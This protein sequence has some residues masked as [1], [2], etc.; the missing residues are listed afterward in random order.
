MSVNLRRFLPGEIYISRHEAWTILKFFWPQSRLTEQELTPDD[1]NFAQGLLVEAIDAS[2]KMGFAHIMFDAFYG[3]VPGSLTD[4]RKLV[5][6]FVK[7]AAKHW[8]K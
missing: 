2:Y 1:I 8:F 3:K 7:K 5:T 4:V 6:A